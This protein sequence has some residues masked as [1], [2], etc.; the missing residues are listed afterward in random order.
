MTYPTIP[1][2][3]EELAALAE[4]VVNRESRNFVND[5][6]VLARWV[7]GEKARRDAIREAMKEEENDNP[8]PQGS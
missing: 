6:M 5:A 3:F 2:T 1:E 7:I 4:R 8:Q